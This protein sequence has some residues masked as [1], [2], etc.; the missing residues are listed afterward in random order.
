MNGYEDTTEGKKWRPSVT[1]GARSGDRHKQEERV[2]TLFTLFTLFFDSARWLI[3]CKNSFV[4][5][6]RCKFVSILGPVYPASKDV[7][8]E[9]TRDFPF[10]FAR[11]A[12]FAL[13][14]IALER[15]LTANGY[16]FLR[17]APDV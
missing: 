15:K 12:P 11:F 9:K 13:F 8:L 14:L 2:F 6:R 7:F 1:S 3:G 16:R 4:K 10:P 5:V 17:Y